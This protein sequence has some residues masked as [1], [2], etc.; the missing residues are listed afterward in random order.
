ML[1]IFFFLL[2]MAVEYEVDIPS[3]VLDLPEVGEPIAEAKGEDKADYTANYYY[4]FYCY[5]FAEK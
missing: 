4:F 3:I 2:G 1:T 5:Y